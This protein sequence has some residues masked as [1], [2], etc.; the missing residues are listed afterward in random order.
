[1]DDQHNLPDKMG[2]EVQHS[3][4]KQLQ[5]ME[6]LKSRLYP[7]QVE[8]FEFFHN[9]HREG[10]KGV[11]LADEMGLGKSIQVISFLANFAHLNKNIPSILLV[12]PANLLDDWVSKIQDW[13]PWMKCLKYH[14]SEQCQATNLSKVKRNGGLLI[15]TYSTVVRHEKELSYLHSSPYCWNFVVFD[16]AH[17]LKNEKTKTYKVALSVQAH[18]R[19]LLT[20]TPIQNNLK[21][22][23]NLLTIISETCLVGT[24]QTFRKN[25][26]NP[27]TRGR[28]ADARADERALTQELM[29][30]LQKTMK[31]VWLR[32]TKEK[33]PKL[34]DKR[35]FVLWTKLTPEQEANYRD[36]LSVN[37][38]PDAPSNLLLLHNLR[39]ICCCSRQF[40][41][42]DLNSAESQTTHSGKLAILIAML[43]KLSSKGH[44]I[45]V[46][47]QY[48]KTLKIAM[49]SLMQTDWGK[50]TVLFM[51]GTVALHQRMMLL[52]SFQNGSQSILLLTVQVGAE[53][54]NLT[55][56]DR[57]IIM[58]PSWNQST[59]AQAVDRV[60]RIGQRR[61]VEVYRL[62]TC[63]TVEEKIYRRQLFKGS[64]AR[65]AVGDDQNP[66]RH[67]TRSELME[68]NS[69]GET[70]Y[71]A[72]QLQL[73]HHNSKR[74]SAEEI[75]GKQ[76]GE[77]ISG[78][79]CGISDHGKLLKA[80]Q[81]EDLEAEMEKLHIADEVQRSKDKIDGEAHLN[82][83]IAFVDAHRHHN[84]PRKSL[85]VHLKGKK[86]FSR[87]SAYSKLYHE[88]SPGL[89]R[90]YKC[91]SSPFS[92]RVQKKRR[93]TCPLKYDS[94][95]G[96]YPE[97]TQADRGE[98]GNSNSPRDPENADVLTPETT[99]TDD[100]SESSFADNNSQQTSTWHSRDKD[101]EVHPDSIIEVDSSDSFTDSPIKNSVTKSADIVDISLNISIIHLSSPK[102]VSTG[103]SLHSAV[104]SKDQRSDLT[105]VQTPRSA[106]LPGN[107]S[108][109]S[110]ITSLPR[111]LCMGKSPQIPDAYTSS[112]PIEPP[113]EKD[114]TGNSI[115]S[116]DPDE[117]KHMPPESIFGDN[118]VP[119]IYFK[120]ESNDEGRKTDP[121]STQALQYDIDQ[122]S[123]LKDNTLRMMAN[124]AQ[125]GEPLQK[126]T[127][128]GSERSEMSISVSS[129]PL[130]RSGTPNNNT[131]SSLSDN[132]SP[133]NLTPDSVIEG[134][135]VQHSDSLTDN[136]RDD[137]V[138]V[139]PEEKN[140]LNHTVT[141][142]D[143]SR[144]M[145]LNTS[146]QHCPSPELLAATEVTLHF[147]VKSQDQTLKPSVAHNSKSKACSSPERYYDLL[148]EVHTPK[149]QQ[150][151][152]Q[153]PKSS[154]PHL[155]P[156]SL[157]DYSLTPGSISVPSTPGMEEFLQVAGVCV[158]SNAVD[159]Q[160]E[161]SKKGGS[162]LFRESRN[163]DDGGPDDVFRI[164]SAS[165]NS[166][167]VNY[168]EES[169]SSNSYRTP[170]LILDSVDEGS[171]ADLGDTYEVTRLDSNKQDESD[172]SASAS[173]EET[174]S[175]KDSLILIT[176]TKTLTLNVIAPPCASLK[177][178]SITD[179]SLPSDVETQDPGQEL[180]D[181][182]TSRQ[183]PPPIISYEIS[184]EVQSREVLSPTMSVPGTPHMEETPQVSV[185]GPDG[186]SEAPQTE[187]CEGKNGTSSRDP[188]K[189]DDILSEHAAGHD[190]V[191]ENRHVHNTAANNLADISIPQN[192]T[193]NSSDKSRSKDLEAEFEKFHT[194]ET[195][196]EAH[197]QCQEMSADENDKS[198]DHCKTMLPQKS[199][200][201]HLQGKKNYAS[202][203]GRNSP[204]VNVCRKSVIKP[205][206]SKRHSEKTPGLPQKY[207]CFSSPFSNSAMRKRHSART[208]QYD[209]D[210]GSVPLSKANTLCMMANDAQIGEPLQKTTDEGSERSEMS[211]SVSSPPLEISG[212]PNNN[213]ES[214]LSDNNSPH[215]LTPDS[216]IEGNEVHHSDSLTDNKSDNIVLV[217]P[218]EKSL[219]K[220]TAT[221][222]DSGTFTSNTSGH[223]SPGL[224]PVTAT[225][226]TL[227]L[228]VKSQDSTLS[229]AHTTRT[230]ACSSLERNCD[231]LREIQ[232]SKLLQSPYQA[233][234][235]SSP[236]LQPIS[237]CDYSLTPG[238]I[239]SHVPSTPSMK[240]FPQLLGVCL[241][242]NAVDPQ[243]EKSEKSNCT[244]LTDSNNSDCMLPEGIS[245]IGRLSENSGTVNYNGES[246]SSDNNCPLSLILDS[247]D[248]GKNKMESLVPISNTETLTLNAPFL[249]CSSPKAVSVT[250]ASLD[251]TSLYPTSELN[252][253]SAPPQWMPLETVVE[254]AVVDTRGDCWLS[255][256]QLDICSSNR[257]DL[258]S[259]DETD[260]NLME[261]TVNDVK[262][263]SLNVNRDGSPGSDTKAILI[264]HS[265][266]F[267]EIQSL[268]QLDPTQSTKPSSPTLP[269]SCDSLT[270]KS[271]Y[272]PSAPHPCKTQQAL[273]ASHSPKEI[274]HEPEIKNSLASRKTETLVGF[275]TP[276]L[277]LEFV[278]EGREADFGDTYEMARLDST[279]QDENDESASASLE[280]T[281]PKKDSLILITDTKTLTLNVIA[282]PCASPKTVSITDN[283]LPSDVETQDPGQE[284]G[285]AKT[286][287]QEPPPIKSYDISA[288]VQSREVLSPTQVL[289]P[290]SLFPSPV[291]FPCD[292]SLTAEPMS[293]P[294]TPHMEETPQVSVVGPDGDGVAPQTEEC[295]GKNGT[296]SRDPHKSND[297]LSEHAAGHDS[298][299]ENRHV[300]N[301]AANNLADISI[302]QNLTPN[303]SDKS[304]S[305]DLETE[306]EKFHTGETEYEAHLQCQEVSADEDYKSPDHCKTKLPQK[307]L[308]S[309]LQ[310]KKNDAGG[311]GR[312][313]PS[314]NVCRKSVI[315]PI[316]SKWHS[317]KTP[318]LP[319]K[320]ICFSSPFS[321]SAMRK[322][323]SARTLQ[324]DLDQGSVPLS[325][326][327]TL[328]MMANDAQIGEPLQKTT[329]E[330]SERSEMSIS[331]SS[332]PLEISGTPNNNTESSLS[333]NNSPHNLTPDSVIEGNEV[334]HSDSLTDNKSDNIVLVSPE[335]KSL[336]K[337]TATHIDSGTFTSNTSGHS[338]PGLEPVT[339]TDDTLCLEV[340]S[341]DSTLSVAHTTRTK[342][343]SSLERNCDLLREIQ[344]SKLLQS[345]YQA[346]KPSSPHLQP[347]SLCDYSLTPGSIMSHV[348]S[349][350]SMKEF[351]QLLGVCLGSNAVDPQ[352]E[353]SEKSN[354]TSLTDSN[355]SDCMLPEGISEIGR[356]SENSGTVNY[357]GES[358]SSDNNCPLSLILDSLDKG[359]NKME[360]LVP[361]SN[362]ETLT[363]NA[364][365]LP[366]SSPKAVSVTNASLDIT[367]LYPTS[368]L[369]VVSAP[370]Q[371]MPLET[372]VEDAVVDTRG[373]C[374]LSSDQ[375]DICSSNRS[376]L[377]SSDETDQNLMEETV[378]D[379]K[380][381]SLNVNRDG[382]PGSDTK[383]ILITHSTFF[384]EIQSLGQLD[385]T[386]STKPSSPTLPL[387]CDSLT[388]KS[389]YLPSAPHPCKTQ[390][391]LGA[392]HSPK[393]II[394]EPEIKN[395]LASRK[396]ETLV[397]FH[398]PSLILEFVDEGREADFGDTYEMARL[399]S[400]RQDE[401]DESASASLEETSPKKDSLILITDTKTLTLNVIAPPCA[402]P[403]TV[404]I[405][406]NSLPSD[407]ETQDPGQELGDAKTSRQEPPPIKSYDISAE[408]QSREVLSPTQVLTPLSLFPS[409][410]VFPCDQSLTA[411]PM[412]VP[413]TPHMEETPQV[414]VVGP[415]GDGVAPQTEE[416]E[417]KNGTSSRDP[418][419]SN[420][421]LSEHAAGHDSVVENRH[422]HNTAANNLADISIPQNLTPNSSDKSRSKDLETEFEKFHTGETE[423]EAHLQCQEVSADE[424][425]KSPDH[426]KTKLPQ[427]SLGS[428]LQ[429]KKNDAG[430]NGRNSP[431]VNVCRKS[432]IKPIY[433]KRHS[434]KTPGLPQK[435]ICFSSPFSN[436]AMR[437]RHS[438]RTLQYDLDQG[439]VPLSKANTLCMMANDAQIGEPLQKTTDEGSERSE[440]SISVS[441]PPLEISGTPNNNTESSLSD[442]NSPH[443]L[444]PDSVIE[445]NEVHHSDS[446]TDNKSDNIVL[447][448]PEE[449]SLLKHTAT[450]ID[451]GTFTSNTS[452]HSSPGLEPVTATDD[453]LCLEVKSQ[454]STLSV[455]HTTRTKACSSLERNCDLLREIQS[456]KLLQSPYQASK[457]S[458]P[459][460]QP[461]SL[462]D[463]S[464]TPGSIMSH[465]PSTPS[466][467][468]FP[469][470]LGVCIGSNAVEPQT[471]KTEKS[472]CT[473]LT[474]SNN[475][476]CMLPEGI[477]ETG[478]LSENSGTVNYNE[479]S[480]SSDNN[481]PL[482]LIL[483]SLDK[484]KNKMNSLVQIS[485]TE[486]LTLNAPSLPCS[487]YK[488]VSV[489]NASLDI[490]SLYPTSELNVVSAPPQWM[491]LEA[492]VQQTST[493]KS[494]SGM[495]MTLEENCKAVDVKTFLDFSKEML[496]AIEDLNEAKME[497]A[498]KSEL[499]NANSPH[500]PKAES[501]GNTKVAL[502]E[503]A[504]HSFTDK[505]IITVTHNTRADL[506]LVK[507]EDSVVDTRGDCWLSSDHLDIC[508]SNRSD[509]VS[510]DET[511]QNLMEETVDDVKSVS[512]NVNHDG[513]PGSD[514]KAIPIT[515]SNY[516]AEIQS[517]GQLDPTQTT[518]PFSPTLSLCC[519]SLT[520]KSMYL[521]N[522]PHPCKTQQVLGASYSPKEI[523]HESEIKNSLASRKT[524]T[525]V[526]SIDEHTK[527]LAKRKKR[528]KSLSFQRRLTYFP[529]VFYRKHIK[530]IVVSK[531]NDQ[532]P[533]RLQSFCKTERT[534]D[535]EC[536]VSH[537]E[538]SVS[539]QW[540]VAGVSASLMSTNCSS[541]L[542]SDIDISE[543]D[544]FRSGN[545][546]EGVVSAHVMHH[547][548]T[549]P[550]LTPKRECFRLLRQLKD[551]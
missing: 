122:G 421:I 277:I 361:I 178:V 233:S 309:H 125:I 416:C 107:N 406:D 278:D 246:R 99:F 300:H 287:R 486:T 350:P 545:N 348:P 216:V 484:G 338:S 225:D 456:S 33:L 331:V 362:T 516:F 137:I 119:G 308:G 427:K 299:V 391:A 101:S 50:R 365:F 461:I 305:K 84:Y 280:E 417:G 73:E 423:Y 146:G 462:C 48:I 96:C 469:Q 266:F 214:S 171:E 179:N 466:M 155:Q 327:N 398:T 268:G 206:Y 432:V 213:T 123:L 320:Y 318:G 192:L 200:G 443:N 301:T 522:A 95:Q 297:I 340:K 112:D 212:T 313:S 310:G 273:G 397:G 513:S 59:D 531:H 141:N 502:D 72:T 460:L 448:S 15:T 105:V 535:P 136:T 515:H 175:K 205:I 311:N 296:S 271:M 422:V 111:T 357:N 407:V 253:V 500:K 396:T 159:P 90:K 295:E 375:L 390:Q 69:L 199:L 282:P 336:L 86:V 263:V 343:C 20:G 372:V 162:A 8:G 154:S 414:S 438:A 189:S 548:I 437:K 504:P 247:L 104:K 418:H 110:A 21:E 108:F 477:S 424:D 234:K 433:S 505:V 128:E 534:T 293:V 91:F 401:N 163:S 174:S 526:I 198:P 13:A 346:S 18:F 41:G 434:E 126:T 288:E 541:A 528:N 121:H 514:T 298:V 501:T 132:N 241:G 201:F 87:E 503:P 506:S 496:D 77:Q 250:N 525:L 80:S 28:E 445:G 413:G 166:V 324:Y 46:F 497:L 404:S 269:L 78:S 4:G 26:E 508:S 40:D 353:K 83:Q 71:S 342:A 449:K 479:E 5:I 355:N 544:H 22:L 124:D 191:V 180:G 27:I 442:N 452:G 138:L 494:C 475:S 325:K 62:I 113:K 363:L 529:S 439:S 339:A 79:I 75:L 429:G 272:L 47:F 285:D 281:S 89:P 360:S 364:P 223:S 275:H 19:I 314:V 232:S 186:D 9:A 274:I 518:K 158:G 116:S 193:P 383:A 176:D 533:Q 11:I 382:S 532:S 251:I 317:E 228:E 92:A 173:L 229:V 236:H 489:T 488:A 465:V 93:K 481:C 354:C 248:K 220:H 35:E 530:K 58:E 133:H 148:R 523:I 208:L 118:N 260:Q 211:I 102:D 256:D 65:Q 482:S 493:A 6:G 134:N 81:G 549:E 463:Y 519:D 218:E 304:R 152:Y 376:D 384:A 510:S 61:E 334:H 45:L 255:S 39:K 259:S 379:V 359:K 52:K 262:S 330:G 369:N 527:R 405:T 294:G 392:S 520:S 491:P 341:Q 289:T 167:T 151:P 499:D 419:K 550:E 472:N 351:P 345:P 276:S 517:L 106:P 428:H 306:F 34:P 177:T 470:L 316:Y 337:H 283:S 56:A 243:T 142:I 185:V 366:C 24:Y 38:A 221:H 388:S 490:T 430:G 270:S 144:A 399:D 184:A 190:S 349:T 131:E 389:M 172:E 409:P 373:D 109:N 411:E 168:N 215:N 326:A 240:E 222:I 476:D 16:E 315:K 258:V 547:D 239:M 135:E 290:L 451:S 478:R 156:I 400:T 76:L 82:C 219:L 103:A 94:D 143:D 420:D 332:P 7:Y 492:V 356:L 217:S 115:L 312:N 485:N 161:K 408:V 344:S 44:K 264:T 85:G 64:L 335:E 230:K 226:D 347:I 307:S 292:Q 165:G 284:L 378:N 441:S 187:E 37:K 120:L 88:K 29:E 42:H 181:A 279:R 237:L 303:S 70:Q 453:T 464:L 512:L 521:P 447:V 254:D 53:G 368:E 130:E 511:D 74:L 302:P 98:T 55:T 231:L 468:E 252:V 49:H 68:L 36:Q 114:K 446:L 30:C 426:C 370:P 245:E 377:V 170:S 291:V 100:R 17:R 51:D 509:L 450:H 538:E 286:S 227:C 393:E 209:L 358:R 197:L 149:Q 459:H 43:K 147:E 164:G 352:T 483:D 145:T 387:S 244:S 23:W 542:A 129:P 127:D 385:P 435:Y 436:S 367:S 425:Y 12:V 380:S 487:S 402:S 431:S 194:G 374:W 182:K 410:V 394:H 381:V 3:P 32:R 14:Q 328:C 188:H 267:A 207:I 257:S 473:S 458:S 457:P 319:Q 467:K 536:I 371:W 139:S 333:D 543:S 1:M 265:T 169:T 471:E 157:C 455:A 210:Q 195:E 444:T 235:P 498:D 196:Y 249:P 10:R 31:P 537:S 540:K 261:E 322:R 546:A 323:H 454:D 440:M 524:E 242:S 412:S 60:H 54:L 386:Q 97:A 117:S 415:D 204:S 153:A 507:L 202:G 321:N 224:E 403:K 474:D 395:S 238:S 495:K 67:F 57:V 2:K 140:T 551:L 25:F 183:E 480:R 329:D 63:G 160:T 150:S 66:L 539:R 203:N